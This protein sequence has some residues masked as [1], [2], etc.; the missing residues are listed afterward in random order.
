MMKTK[1]QPGWD[2]PPRRLLNFLCGKELSAVGVHG[3][4][5]TQNTQ[6]IPDSDNS[7]TVSKAAMFID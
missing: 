4:I 1:M 5:R 3:Q 2:S 6:S 7:A